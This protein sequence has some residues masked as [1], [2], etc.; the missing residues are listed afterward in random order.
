MIDSD[1]SCDITDNNSWE[2]LKEMHVPEV[3]NEYLCKFQT[4]IVYRNTSIDAEFLALAG[5]ERPL[6]DSLS[7]KKL[8]ILRVGPEINNITEC[9]FK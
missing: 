6:L 2:Y 3:G 5:T 7:A 1:S 9:H 4:S 8:G